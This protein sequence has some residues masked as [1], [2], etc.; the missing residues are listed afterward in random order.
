METKRLGHLIGH[1]SILFRRR[2]DNI[3]A[4]ESRDYTDS[5]S[6]RNM[7]ILRYLREHPS[8]DVFQRDLETAFKLR[9]S[10][11]SR[12][13]EL[14]EQKELI[15]RE[16]VNGDARLKRLCLTPKAERIVDAVS[17]G[18]DRME[19]D[20]RACFS[21]EDYENLVCLLEKLGS[22]LEKPFAEA[23]EEHSNEEAPIGDEKGREDT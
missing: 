20:V 7:W 12:T 11:I 6:G 16:S 1:A 8:E 17:C 2:F 14:M 10:T 23:A 3:V 21:E 19:Q 18:V 13:V 5:L 15:R 22:I 4:E 9:R